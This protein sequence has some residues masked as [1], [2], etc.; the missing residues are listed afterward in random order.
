MN[1][2][3]NT[4]P[5]SAKATA[6]KVLSDPATGWGIVDTLLFMGPNPIG[7]GICLV[8]T[9]VVSA[10][11]ATALR[12]PAFLKKF[13]KFQEKI[14]DPKI[15]LNIGGTALMLV[16][17]V[18]LASV[19]TGPAAIT[20]TLLYPSIASVLYGVAKYRIAVSIANAQKQQA[21]KAAGEA[22]P[23]PSPVTEKLTF[24]KVLTTMVKSPDLYLNAGAAFAGLMSGGLALLCLPV[25]AVAYGIS[26]RNILLKKPEH[27]GHPKAIS[28]VARL[29]FGIIG[30]QNGHSLIGAAQCLNTA[31][32]ANVEAN[33]TPGGAKQI[34]RDMKD[35]VQNI[36]SKRRTSQNISPA[37][38]FCPNIRFEAGTFVQTASSL[39]ARFTAT[40]NS[41]PC[42]PPPSG[43]CPQT[44]MR[45]PP[46]T[47][48]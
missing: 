23:A 16:A 9:A 20:L 44:V 43:T 27:T 41:K 10:V 37:T 5:L 29:L 17:A 19:L 14:S 4:Q 47:A 22:P 18:G 39:T 21:A 7:A 40:R 32:L 12:Q 46:Q 33:I 2:T 28:A 35:G 48:R 13:P 45:A 11:K 34:W 24:K 3:A 31:I 42:A 6:K 15:T 26:L 38:N 1:K 30:F 36:F 25:V 8:S